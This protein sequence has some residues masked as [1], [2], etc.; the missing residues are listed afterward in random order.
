MHADPSDP[1]SLEATASERSTTGPLRRAYLVVSVLLGVLVVFAQGIQQWRLAEQVRSAEV[2]NVA[3]RQRMLSQRMVQR[4]IAAGSTPD[5]AQR[6][7]WALDLRSD[8]SAWQVGANRLRDGDLATFVEPQGERRRRELAEAEEELGARLSAALAALGTRRTG[9]SPE[10]LLR[11]ADHYLAIQDELVFAFSDQQD[12]RLQQVRLVALSLAL[13]V[14]ATVV[15]MSALVFEPMIRHLAEI[16]RRE[17]RARLRLERSEARHARA[18]KGSTD[19]IWDWAPGQEL[20]WSPRVR[21]LL[22]IP[23]DAEP[24]WVAVVARAVPED[25]LQLERDLATAREGSPIDC[26][27][28]VLRDGRPHHVQ[29]RGARSSDGHISGVLADAEA[30]HQL[31]SER[32]RLQAARQAERQQSA[33]GAEARTRMLEAVGSLAAG[34]AHDLNNA[35]QVISVTADEAD[36]RGLDVHSVRSALDHARGLGSQL[37]ALSPGTERPPARERLDLAAWMA[38]TRPVVDRLLPEAITLVVDIEPDLPAVDA[39]PVQLRQ[40]V[41]QVVLNA[42]DAID[43][44]GTVRL[45]LRRVRAVGLDGTEPR[46][47]VEICIQDDGPGMPEE[48]ATRAFEPFFTTKDRTGGTGLGLSM[49]HGILGRH[50]GRVDLETAPG[51]GTAVC[52]WLPATAAETHTPDPAPAPYGP[53]TV[54]YIDD[55]PDLHRMIRRLLQ[56]LGYRS[57]EAADGAAAVRVA[58]EARATGRPIDVLLCDVMLA[59][60]H[61]P[62]VVAQLQLELA[63]PAAVIYVSGYHDVD[64][65]LSSPRTTFLA[66]PFGAAALGE[67]VRQV[68][69]APP[70]KA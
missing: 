23:E 24:S 16:S 4:A 50:G 11:Y 20:Y 7:A 57:L 1:V 15:A 25:R 70:S 65:D 51:S 55:N 32:A 8:L 41:V 34:I 26:T 10:A 58:R 64:V 67:A 38:H 43:G 40:A 12:A 69:G 18:M 28:R 3:G 21:T 5:D 2:V 68:L 37:L 17:H 47:G 35:L 42:R 39:D 53:R 27:F 48:V 60:E 56:H 63:P 6:E 61:G 22:D 62:D 19:G 52:L 46:D 59:S 66:K 29:L 30:R 14:V 45:H 33:G 49:V 13:L 54:L 31:D 44:H 36:E 9:P